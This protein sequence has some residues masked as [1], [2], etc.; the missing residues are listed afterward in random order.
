MAMSPLAG[1]ALTGMFSYISDDGIAHLRDH[2]FA[3]AESTPIDQLMDPFWLAVARRLPRRISPNAVSVFGGASALACTVAVVLATRYASAAAHVAAGFLLLVYQTADAVDGK[4]ARL[5]RQ[6]TP[7]G[8]FVDHGIDAFVGFCLGVGVC[9]VLD[10]ELSTLTMVGMCAFHSTWFAAQVC[11]LGTGALDTRGVTEGEFAAAAVLALPGLWRLD[12]YASE[13]MLPG[14]G[15][16][17]ARL[18]LEVLI[19]AG[20][21]IHTAFQAAVALS[22][23]G[24]RTTCAPLLHFGLHNLVGVSLS[25]A[26][27]GQQSPLLALSSV[28]MD[29]CMLMTK[30]RLTVLTRTPWK[31][32]LDG[33][34]FLLAAVAN[35]AGFG[36]G[37]PIFGVVLLWQVVAFVLLWHDSI[38]RICRSLD[39]PFLAEV[40]DKAQ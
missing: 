11:E 7:L 5:T 36:V 17:E 37:P 4:H 25:T 1:S 28:G 10:P 15:A 20:C 13:L 31:M 39:I 2:K 34:P 40:P 6:S 14:V 8:S 16:V 19:A 27:L 23:P 26:S 29:A 18:P 38:S 35:I 24:A 22:G 9:V 12:V 32:Q 33:L 30:A 3:A 21:G